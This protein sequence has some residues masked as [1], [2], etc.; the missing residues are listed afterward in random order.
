MHRM[1]KKRTYLRNHEKRY[2]FHI[3]DMKDFSQM[4]VAVKP[5]IWLKNNFKKS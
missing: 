3:K 2:N 1:I 4:N 5:Y